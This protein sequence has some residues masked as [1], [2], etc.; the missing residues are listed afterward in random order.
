M[1]VGY[2]RLAPCIL[3]LLHFRRCRSRFAEEEIALT[4]AGFFSPPATVR[5]GMKL[6][7][8]TGRSLRLGVLWRHESLSVSDMTCPFRVFPCRFQNGCPTPLLAYFFP[9]FMK[10]VFKLQCLMISFFYPNVNM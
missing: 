6:K 3:R 1:P 10:Q 4:T 8:P 7:L 2:M 9:P 5:V